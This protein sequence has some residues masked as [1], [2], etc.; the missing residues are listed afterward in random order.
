MKLS[1]V[2]PYS[3][4]NLRRTLGLDNPEYHDMVAR[5]RSNDS[6][7]CQEMVTAYGL[8]EEQVRHAAARYRLGRSRSGKTIYW[9]IDHEGF[10]VDGLIGSDASQPDC[11]V[12]SLLRRRYPALAD[13][14]RPD[15]CL[16]GQHLLM[17]DVR[18][19]KEDGRGSRNATLCP[20]TSPLSPQPSNI[21]VVERMKSAVVLS[22]LYPESLW[23]ATGYAANLRVELLKPL[24]GRRVVLFPPT[25]S[26]ED[27]YYAWME[28]ADQA[29]RCYG[30]DIS[31]SAVLE[32][33]CSPE[34]KSRHIDLVDYLFEQ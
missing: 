30:L 22:E 2:N 8:S 5:S 15:H 23:M 14:L 31:V 10:V 33:Q 3:F 24:Q 29:R 34:Q 13:Y 7:L 11:W 18:W 20:P 26:T 25:D 17:S 19:K 12:N 32:E 21:S 27:C 28:V 1:D 6:E 9:M 16:F 4:R